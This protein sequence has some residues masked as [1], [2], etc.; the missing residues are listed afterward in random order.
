MA[1]IQALINQKAGGPQGNPAPVYYQLAATEYGSSGNSS[2]N[3]SNGVS[4][5]AS[6]IFYDVTLGDMDVDCVGPNCY[7]A[8]GSVGV[9]S[10]S[11]TSFAPAYGT[12]VG[13][14][15]ATGIGTLNAANL[16]NN[17][18]GAAQTPSFTLSAL[19]SSL[20]IVQG[21]SGSSTITVVPQ[22]GFSGS[23][24]F[25]ASGLPGGVTASFA[26]NPSNTS[27]VL[28]LSANATATTGTF[29]ITVTGTSGSL[30]NTTSLSLAVTPAADFTLSASPASLSI[31]QGTGA[32]TTITVNPLNG[33]S[34]NVNLSA[35]G[36]PSGVTASFIPNPTAN[37]STLTL[38]ANGSA[39]TGTFTVTITGTS[40]V[41]THTTTVSL[42]V[43]AAPNFSLSASPS[44]LSVKR[45]RSV[46]TTITISRLNGFTSSVSLAASGLPSG[47]T[48]TFSLNPATTSSTL[49][50]RTSSTAAR[51][52]FLVTIT[53]TSGAL[54][55]TTTISLNVH[56]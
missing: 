53:G 50:L 44:S 5:A 25:S 24:T 34:S 4:V 18:P 26:P 47:V 13:W 9:L 51:G 3:S 27:S 36:L 52:T 48:A 49:T 7:L 8:D 12:T 54:Q 17:W 45:G 21:T 56:N 35:S 6:C 39:A 19:P 38:S 10:T 30:T 55:H 16:V 43:T 14:D 22:N 23:V 11:D 46:Q 1:G 32:T 20:S 37:T 40:G 28:T 42:T 29:T 2:C 33:F 41:L 15:F 31:V